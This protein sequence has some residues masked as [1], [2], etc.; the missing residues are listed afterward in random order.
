MNFDELTDRASTISSKWGMQEQATGVTAS[1]GLPMWIADMDFRTPDFITNAAQELLDQSFYGYFHTVEQY[2]AAICWWMENR[3]GWR[4]EDDAVLTTYG[5][6]NAIGLMCHAFTEP[7][8]GVMIFTPVYDEF[9]RVINA[10]GRTVIECPLEIENGKYVMNFAAY[11]ALVTPNTKM[12][13]LCSPHNP[14]GRVWTQAELREVADF[15]IR[16]DLILLSDEIHQDLVFEGHTHIPMPVAAP[17]AINRTLVLSAASK[18]FNIA[19]A[20]T[21]NVIAPDPRLRKTV[22]DLLSALSIQPN[23]FGKVMVQ[24]AYSPAGA[25][26]TD[27]LVAYLQEGRDI[28]DAG[29]SAI[30]GVKFMPMES[31]YLS[32]VD[33]SALG[34]PSDEVNRRVTQDARIGPKFGPKF[35]TGGDGYLRFNFGTQHARIREAVDRLQHAFRDV[36]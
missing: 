25:S 36:Q 18:T 19:G 30:P 1:D 33:F 15:C 32:W 12:V 14:A 31:T 28:L 3:H 20:R 16:H 26:W 13:I 35:G 11:D 10:G 34:M 17:D 29:V 9:A 24:A 5:L 8:D 7:G 2:R 6:G 27:D 21:G 22:K 4:V 23:I